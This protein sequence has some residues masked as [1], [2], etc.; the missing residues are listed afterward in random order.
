[1]RKLLSAI[2]AFAVL[3][4]GF[5]SA[6]AQTSSARPAQSSSDVERRVEFILKQMTLEEKIDMLGGVDGFFIRDVPRLGLPRLKMADGPLGVRNFGPATAMAGGVSLAATWNPQLAER[7]GTEIGRDARAKGVNFLLGPG[8][9]IYRAPMN[10]RNFE[11]FGEDPYLASRVAVGYVRGVQSQGVSATIKHYMGNNSEFDRHNTDSRIDERTMREIYLPTFEA[12]VKEA[13]VGA[14]MDS[15]NLVNGEHASQNHHLLTEIVKQDWGFD[16]LIMSDW[17]ATYDGVAASDGGQ[18]LEMP[19][20]EHMNRKTL[21]PAAEKSAASAAAIDDHVRRILRTAIRFDWLEGDQTDLSIPRFNQRGRQVALEAAREGMVLLKNGGGLL[22]LD[23]KKIKSV[24]VIGPDA[25]PAVPVG[26][27]SAGVQPFAS[28]SFLEGI[29]NRLG[30]SAQVYYNRGIP[31]L[32]DMAGATDFKTAATGGEAGLR[33]EYFK[34]DELKG[35]PAVTRNEQHVA[36]GF[37]GR[38]FPADTLSSRWSGYYT[39][40]DSG[41]YEIFVASSGEDGGLFRLYVDDKLVFDNWTTSR[42]LVNQ[43]ALTLGAGP[44]K[45]LLEQHGRSYWLGGRMQLGILRR[46]SFVDPAAKQLASKADAVVLAVG[47]DPA[48][49]ARALTGLSTCR[50]DRTS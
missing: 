29:S 26:G 4:H 41:Q 48:R 14:I 33:A 24:A 12:A 13:H 20:G 28:V 18:D 1:M 44:H 38:P 3:V 39:A 31:S 27:G 11:Y 47:F 36:L 5:L 16:G 22:P 43:T 23:G 25:Y 49:R 32:G 10:G 9:N 45:V 46:G 50:P 6:P 30:A 8:V 21:A 7:V 37:G 40:K 2:A 17:G 19:S 15:Y 34:N 35:P 42:A